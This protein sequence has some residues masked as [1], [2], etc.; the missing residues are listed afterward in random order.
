MP[1]IA[2]CTDRHDLGDERQTALADHHAYIETILDRVAVA[3]PVTPAPGATTEASCFI[4]HTDDREEARQ[5]LE[6]TDSPVAEIGEA[7]GY[8][9]TPSF[10]RVFKRKTGLTPAEHRKMFG[11]SRFSGYA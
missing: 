8:V 9:D 2:Y 1:H 5:L 10:R 4:Y 11:K 7:V 6:T 3:G